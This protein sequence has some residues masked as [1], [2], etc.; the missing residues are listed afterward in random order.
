LTT[1]MRLAVAVVV[2]RFV[3]HDRQVM[4]SLVF[5]PVRDLVA[6]SVWI[7]SFTGHEVRWRGDRFRLEKGKLVRISD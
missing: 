7:L 4:R 3:L 2:G 5:I 6:L 1:A